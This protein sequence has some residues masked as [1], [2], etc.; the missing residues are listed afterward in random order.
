MKNKLLPAFAGICI[1]LFTASGSFADTSTETFALNGT[2]SFMNSPPIFSGSIIQGTVF[3]GTF[4]FEFDDTG[5]PSPGDPEARWD[6]IF[7]HYFIY[8]DTPD[9][10]GW[11]GYFPPTGS[12]E[13]L[14]EWRFFTEAGDTLGGLC[15]GFIITIRDYNANGIMEEEEYVNKVM[16]S[17]MVVWINFG[18]GCFLS[19]CGNGNFSGTLDLIDP[20][21]R[22]EEFYVPSLTSASGRLYLR[23]FGCSTDVESSSWGKIKSIYS[24]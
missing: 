22:E 13:P 9:G 11:D 14:V 7:S 21:T 10:E 3:P 16:S 17:N 19:F 8:D 12:G 2:G 6:Y 5:W 1:I 23:D 24:D 4:W 20:E 15:N 18:G